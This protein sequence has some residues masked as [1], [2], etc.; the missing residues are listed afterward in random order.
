MSYE[1]GSLLDRL[2]AGDREALLARGIRRTFPSGA[3]LFREGERSAH[4]VVVLSGRTKISFTDRDGRESI[5]NVRGAGDLLGELSV[6]DGEPH[7]ATVLALE[8]VAAAVVSADEFRTLLSEHP[9]LSM[10]LLELVVARLRD[11]DR[12]R[13][14]F[15]AYDTRGRVARRLVELAQRFGEEGRAGVRITLRL[16]QEELAGWTGSSR[17]AVAKALADFRGRGW[18]ETGRRTVIVL[19]PSALADEAR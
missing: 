13:V 6:L 2:P 14:E 17:E 7:S 19:D 18:V 15:G 1:H 9:R 11:A 10:A 5:L 4:V 8:P 16:T 12:K 3:I